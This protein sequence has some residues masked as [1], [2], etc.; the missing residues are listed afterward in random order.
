MLIKIY[1]ASVSRLIHISHIRCSFLCCRAGNGRTLY[2]SNGLKAKIIGSEGKAIVAADGSELGIY[3]QGADGGATFPIEGGGYYYVSNS[4]IGEQY[5]VE[6]DLTAD[7]IALETNLTGGT[8]AWEFNSDHEVVGYQQ[9]L[10]LTT[11]NC[12]GGATPWGSFVSCEERR[13]WGQCWQG[14]SRCNSHRNF[15]AFVETY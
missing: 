15:E 10:N 11:G 3:H 6:F 13:M 1:I 5:A 4:E 8:Y 14:K 7:R 12:A 9:I 2:L